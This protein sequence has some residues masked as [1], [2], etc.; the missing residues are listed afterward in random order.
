MKFLLIGMISIASAFAEDY[1]NELSLSTYFGE[2][3]YRSIGLNGTFE[4]EDH[5]SLFGGI[6]FSQDQEN[7]N[8]RFEFGAEF[9]P[10][11]LFISLSAL[12][13]LDVE[14]YKGL[15]V[16]SL[17]QYP[18]SLFWSDKDDTSLSIGGQ[19]IQY[20]QSLERRNTTSTHT[21]RIT[22]ASFNL[23]Q[24]ID[25]YFRVSIGA[26]K[27]WVPE[28]RIGSSIYSRRLSFQSVS[29]LLSGFPDWSA[30]LTLGGPVVEHL[31]FEIGASKTQVIQTKE[32]FIGGFI[33]VS[34]KIDS[35]WIF[36]PELAYSKSLLETTGQW[37][38]LFT[39]NY[40]F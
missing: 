22:T 34:W 28:S 40:L 4:I 20:F 8:K 10:S 6:Q 24:W 32:Q 14:D 38:S 17:F 2:Q 23:S 36:S 12:G 1:K 13:A 30:Y 15:G 7:E 9:Y 35:Q 31:D 33:N 3:G 26:S 16:K 5:W 29:G 25:D 37:N 11:D 18:I 39:V 21:F 27:S 19:W